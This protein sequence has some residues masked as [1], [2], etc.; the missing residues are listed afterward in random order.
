MQQLSTFLDN[1]SSP[2][3]VF[4]RISVAFN[5]KKRLQRPFMYKKQMINVFNIMRIVLSESLFVVP[6]VTVHLNH[7]TLYARIELYECMPCMYMYV[8]MYDCTYGWMNGWMDVCMFVYT[9]MYL[10]FM[11]VLY[12]NYVFMC[13]YLYVYMC[14]YIYMYV[15]GE[16]AL[17][18]PE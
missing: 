10:H 17:R 9:G 14:V 18:C 6:S 11:Y 1:A 5:V 3:P 7:L 13:I 8:C 16:S 4:P 15:L 2:L 12:T